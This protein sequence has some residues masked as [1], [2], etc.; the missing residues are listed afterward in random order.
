M[1]KEVQRVIKDE[2]LTETRKNRIV[3][4]KLTTN[5]L[6]RPDYK[7]WEDRKN[8]KKSLIWLYL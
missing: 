1:V 5:K 8:P 6:Y 3:G 4:K 2:N 7:V